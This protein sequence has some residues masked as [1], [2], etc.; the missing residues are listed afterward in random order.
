MR[1]LLALPVHAAASGAYVAAF[2]LEAFGLAL[3]GHAPVD[4]VIRHRAGSVTA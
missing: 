2:W 1:R 4:E 3:A